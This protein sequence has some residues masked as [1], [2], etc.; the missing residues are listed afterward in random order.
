M[1]D[2]AAVTCADPAPD[3]V[4]D[5]VLA[6]AELLLLLLLLEQ[7]A[8]A[9]DIIATIPSMAGVVRLQRRTVV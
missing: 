1:N 6:P 5:P 3:A 2:L 8:T 7:A 9:M 4:A